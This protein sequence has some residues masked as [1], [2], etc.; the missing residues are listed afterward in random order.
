[1][2]VERNGPVRAKSMASDKISELFAPVNRFVDKHAHLM[3]DENLML[4]TLGNQFAG[5]DWG[6]HSHKEYVR[7]NI[8]NNTA[9]SFN[10]ILE[11]TKQNTG[12]F[13]I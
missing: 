9:E 2:A 7:G 10:S 13:I 6:D 4:V 11:R 12:Y 1:M 3:S 8:H 5:H